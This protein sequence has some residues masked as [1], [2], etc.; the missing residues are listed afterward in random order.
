VKQSDHDV[1]YLGM[2]CL[3]AESIVLRPSKT[4]QENHIVYWQGKFHAQE[5]LHFC[6]VLHSTNRY[7]Q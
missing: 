6:H 2:S 5:A 3:I 1:C 7:G 4:S